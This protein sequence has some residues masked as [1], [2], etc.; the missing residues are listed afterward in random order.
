MKTMR[1]TSIINSENI[2]CVNPDIL[3]ISMYLE[4]SRP[5]GD[6]SRWSKVFERLSLLNINHPITI[7]NKCP[8][9]NKLK[10]YKNKDDNEIKTKLDIL[11]KTIN[12]LK[13]DKDIIIFGSTIFNI[14]KSVDN[15]K[16]KKIDNNLFINNPN[17]M[18]Y[19]DIIA[20]DID[21]SLSKIIELFKK[22][23]TISALVLNVIL[24]FLVVLLNA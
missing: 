21:E 13:T 2:K 6:I 10:K 23:H 18:T 11:D 22:P 12:Y 5:D 16:I 20:L 4:L 3:R 15:D 8:I 1:E 7:E 24:P 14:Y 17:L 19:F 9:D